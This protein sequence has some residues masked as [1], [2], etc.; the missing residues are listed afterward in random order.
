MSN[1]KEYKHRNPRLLESNEVNNGNSQSV[2]YGK[3]VSSTESLEKTELATK[4]NLDVESCTE[5]TSRSNSIEEN[6]ITDVNDID[7]V[8]G[9]NSIDGDES[10]DQSVSNVNEEASKVNT[11][12]KYLPSF[13]DSIINRSIEESPMAPETKIRC[14]DTSIP[15]CRVNENNERMKDM[16]SDH[17]LSKIPPTERK[18][19]PQKSCVLCRKYGAR[20]DTRYICILCNA[21]LCKEPCFSDYHC[22]K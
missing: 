12:R 17:T 5:A 20:N 18:K 22:S 11:K 13:V 1:I 6:D 16:N 14:L 15:E 3:G 9:E 8:Y 2:E 4:L 19:W 10:M 21:A 7:K